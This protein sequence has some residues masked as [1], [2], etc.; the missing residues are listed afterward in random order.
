[1]LLILVGERLAA[2]KHMQDEFGLG[3]TLKAPADSFSLNIV[4]RF[5]QASSVDKDHGDASDTGGFLDGVTRG[6]GRGGDDGTVVA[7]QLVEQAGLPGIG[8]ADD[9]RTNSVAKDL[10]FPG[11]GK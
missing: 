3:N 6:A 4:C 9:R 11:R 2:I 7:K 8:P 5:T 1:M 10:S